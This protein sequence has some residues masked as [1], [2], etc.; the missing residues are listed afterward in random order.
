MFG[1]ACN[2]YFRC[3]H[4][5]DANSVGWVGSAISSPQSDP[6]C[7]GPPANEKS[8]RAVES[9]ASG[10]FRNEVLP[11]WHLNCL[12]GVLHAGVAFDLRMHQLMAPQG[13]WYWGM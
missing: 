9:F 13:H 8:I 11:V 2:F 10:L 3:L 5:F 6:F 7:G 4:S 1:R 12:T